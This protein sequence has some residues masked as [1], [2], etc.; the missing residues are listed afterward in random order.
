MVAEY[1]CQALHTV[2]GVA[3]WGARHRD[4]YDNR[5]GRPATEM[6]KLTRPCIDPL[7]QSVDNLWNH[8]KNS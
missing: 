4:F 7:S 1:V 3:Q 8:W 6:N 5:I 2:L